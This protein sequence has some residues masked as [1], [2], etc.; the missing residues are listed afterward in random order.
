M[1]RAMMDVVVRATGRYLPERVFTNHDFEGLV[2]TSDEWITERTGIKERRFAA[3]GERVSDMA[4]R[5]SKQALAR[6]GWGADDLDC[7]IVATVTGDT[8]FPATANWLQGKL[9][10]TRGWSFDLNAGCGGFVYALSVATGLLRSGQS[11]RLLLVGAER[12]SALLDFTDRNT[13]VLFGDGAACILLEAVDPADNPLRLGVQDFVLGSDGSLASIL[14]QPA[15]GSNQP[16]TY[17]SIAA[18]DHFVHMNGRDVYM[19]AVRRMEQ[20]VLD[21]LD[22]CGLAPADIDWYIAHQAN[23]RIIST[24]QERATLWQHH[25]GDHP[26]LP[27]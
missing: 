3:P 24:V 13:C 18:H 22:K 2:D 6:A 5:A 23:A 14:Y 12:M 11:S 19:N 25:R 1:T 15:G 17:Q 26:A 4:L 7:V 21:V 27:R 16:P 8:I 10:N 20:V 9:G